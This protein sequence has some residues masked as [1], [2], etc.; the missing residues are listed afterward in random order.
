VA[1]L[2]LPLANYRRASSA[3]TIVNTR[4]FDDKG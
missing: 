4:G 1:K 3:T 2:A